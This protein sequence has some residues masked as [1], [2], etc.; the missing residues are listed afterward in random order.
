MT[1]LY[2]LF[3]INIEEE[4]MYYVIFHSRFLIVT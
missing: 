3:F 2:I 1:L 4:T